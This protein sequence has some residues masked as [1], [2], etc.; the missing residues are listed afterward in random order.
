LGFQRRDHAAFINDHS[1][2]DWD[3]VYEFLYWFAP[4][5]AQ[6]S[7]QRVSLDFD[8]RSADLFYRELVVPELGRIWFARQLSWPVAALA[9]HEELAGVGSNPPK[10]TA[11]CH[12]IEAL[13]CKLEYDANSDPATRSRRILGSRAFGRDDQSEVWSFQQLRQATNYVRNTRQAATR[14]SSRGWP[15]V[16]T[17]PRFDLLELEPVRRALAEPSSTSALARAGRAFGSG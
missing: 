12:G 5:P 11:I 16:G 13:A 8:L 15:G 7:S 10:P 9:L 1:A 3:V 6:V 14:P 2:L 4:A 17:R